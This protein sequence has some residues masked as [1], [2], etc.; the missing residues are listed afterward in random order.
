MRKELNRLSKLNKLS[1]RKLYNHQV[2][3]EEEFKKYILEHSFCR[4][5]NKVKNIVIDENKTRNTIIDIRT[6]TTIF[7]EVS[8]LVNIIYYNNLINDLQNKK[9]DLLDTNKFNLKIIYT[10]KILNGI[11][12]GIS[13]PGGQIS[14]FYRDPIFN[15]TLPSFKKRIKYQIANKYSGYLASTFVP[16]YFI[17]DDKLSLTPDIKN[18]KNLVEEYYINIYGFRCMDILYMIFP[19]NVFNII[20]KFKYT[21]LY[22]SCYRLSK[23]IIK[24]ELPLIW[25][26]SKIIYESLCS[27]ILD[28]CKIVEACNNDDDI[29]IEIAF[30]YLL[31]M[32]KKFILTHLDTKKYQNEINNI[33]YLLDKYYGIT[34]IPDL[35]SKDLDLNLNSK[36]LDLLVWYKE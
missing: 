36:D 14:S 7:H 5:Y 3:N 9:I 20:T 22:I 24:K 18:I 12:T 31:C 34:K 27:N 1:R 19:T 30:T 23:K 16:T 17:A 11:N 4:E 13:K 10:K 32:S 15:N 25:H 21:F 8:H 29:I 28:L 33:T 35:N 2:M 6:F 26:L